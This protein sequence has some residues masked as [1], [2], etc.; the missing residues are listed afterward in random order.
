MPLLLTWL[1]APALAACETLDEADF[2]SYVLDAQSAIDRGDIE[3]PAAILAEV[4]ARLPCLDFSPAPRMWAE[5]L[6]AK[7]IVEYS[8]GG[9]WQA[10][11]ATALRIRPAIDRGVGSGHPMREW[12]A[13]PAP[14]G[15]PPLDAAGVRVF[16]DGLASPTAPP[17]EGLHLVQKTDG[18]FWNSVL[19]LDEPPPPGWLEDPVDQP[20]RVVA[21]GRLG[22]SVG[23]LVAQQLPSAPSQLYDEVQIRGPGG[24]VAGDLHATFFSPIGVLASGSLVVHPVAPALDARVAAIGSWRRVTLGGGVGAVTVHTFSFAPSPGVEPGVGGELDRDGD[25]VLEEYAYGAGL[26]RTAGELPL[27]A[28]VVVGGGPALTR[29][30]VGAGGALRAGDRRLRLGLVLDL[31]R[32]AYVHSVNPALQVVEN[33]AVMSVRLDG[34]WGE[35]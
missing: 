11:L 35:Y 28:S 32:V 15:G 13:P 22:A 6:V 12:E 21:F 18:R 23:G 16:V 29:L 34:L 2:R 25:I 3:L 24:G 10:P 31:R 5:L 19:L 7:A 4:E 14:P 26:F 33:Q 20:S 30:E 8:R 17:S 27:D 1:A 9:D